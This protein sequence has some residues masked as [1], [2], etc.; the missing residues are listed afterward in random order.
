[1]KRSHVFIGVLVCLMF[2]SAIV[3][4]FLL[5]PPMGARTGEEYL[6]TLKAG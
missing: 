5:E 4:L 3:A 2:I 6:K 1:M